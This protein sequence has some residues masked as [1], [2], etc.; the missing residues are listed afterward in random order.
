MADLAR[1][2]QIVAEFFEI[3]HGTVEGLEHLDRYVAEDYI[4]HNPNIEQGREGLRKF[5]TYILSLPPEERLDPAK[6]IEVNVIAD[7]EFIARQA[8]R[9]D[10][11]LIDV[12]RVR[13]GLL[14]EHWDA[15]RSPP[16]GGRKASQC[17]TSSPSRMRK[18]SISMPS[19]R[20][21]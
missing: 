18:T 17:S 10:G 5:F 8:I 6:E 13:G 19:S 16:G 2:K 21:A 14:V 7:G 1:N 3:A 9:E 15:F 4:Q 12:F 20:I 11:M